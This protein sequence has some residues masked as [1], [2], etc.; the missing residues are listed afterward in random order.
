[1]RRVRAN[2]SYKSAQARDVSLLVVNSLLKKGSRRT[3]R[4]RS[5]ATDETIGAITPEV[6]KR[7]YWTMVSVETP[8]SVGAMSGGAGAVPIYSGPAR[9]FLRSNHRP[10]RRKAGPHTGHLRAASL[11]H[12][13]HTAIL[14][15]NY[16]DLVWSAETPATNSK[17][18][19]QRDTFQL[20][21]FRCPISLRAERI[22]CG[23]A[24]RRVVHV[25][26]APPPDFSL[27]LERNRLRGTSRR[28]GPASSMVAMALPGFSGA[29]PPPCKPTAWPTA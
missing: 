3:L 13:S 2:V 8:P 12:E 22:S 14:E 7:S 21:S 17:C 20:T 6:F 1:M 10:A 27:V 16:A 4:I 24:A 19:P 29:S 11:A 5:D 15:G 28:H 26:F 9:A 23:Q 18:W 25:E